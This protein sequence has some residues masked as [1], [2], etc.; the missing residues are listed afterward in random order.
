MQRPLQPNI[1]REALCCSPYRPLFQQA[2][3]WLGRIGAGD[4]EGPAACTP[5]TINPAAVIGI[6]RV[7]IEIAALANNLT[8][9]C[10]DLPGALD[11]LQ[12]IVVRAGTIAGVAEVEA[13][14]AGMVAAKP[15][16]SA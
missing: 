2:T 7:A 4:G 11:A 15:V 8:G 12:A 5:G 9:G 13:R 1:A 3:E 14:R 10:Y 6:E 16:G